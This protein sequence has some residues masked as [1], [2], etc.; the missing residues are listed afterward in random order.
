VKS[1]HDQN[2]LRVFIPENIPLSN[3]GEEAIVRGVQDIL[4]GEDGVE[5]AILGKNISSVILQ[6]KIKVFPY[7]W[8]YDNWRTAHTY[9]S[10][11][12]LPEY[13]QMTFRRLLNVFLPFW[14]FIKPL[15]QF[16]I[17]IAKSRSCLN[18]YFD[19]ADL[20]LVGHDGV[21]HEQTCHIILEAKRRGKIVGILGCGLAP[22]PRN[23]Q[24]WKLYSKAI[25]ATD[26]CYFRESQSY[27]WIKGLVPSDVDVRLAPDPAF[28]MKHAS[29][30][31]INSIIKRENMESLFSR[32]I[33]MFT[34][35]ENDII[36]KWGFKNIPV[37]KDKRKAHVKLIASLVDHITEKWDAKV[38]FLPHSIGL[39]DDDRIVAQ[40]VI[41]H[42]KN[43]NT[44]IINNEYD[45]KELKGLISRAD[46][47]I[48]ERIH[49]LIGAISIGVPIMCI[50]AQEDNRSVDI[51]GQMCGMSDFTYF[52]D[53]PDKY[54]LFALA[55]SLWKNRGNNRNHRDS[56]S[57]KLKSE[58]EIVSQNI[59]GS[60][61]P[62]D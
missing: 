22:R 52:L 41:E 24:I 14:V 30:I 38:L 4:G 35:V 46:M 42:T 15:S 17:R 43:G 25:S 5:L 6:G 50:G 32:N 13:A 16:Y 27:S 34:V 53:N 11:N 23:K 60:M 37:S 57:N 19:K 31:D 20:I 40:K 55:D 59:L 10:F 9:F 49:S 54:D 3:K 18:E 21:F 8:I 51:V 7:D 29:D 44:F 58:L 47:L 2:K 28:G 62:S 36:N 26:F 39:N 33:V 56:I 48:G 1:L 61:H 12:H 45:A